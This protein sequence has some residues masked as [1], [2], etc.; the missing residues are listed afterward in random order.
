[1]GAL[2]FLT[3]GESHGPGLVTIVEGMPAGVPIAAAEIDRDLVRRQRGYGRGG[4]QKI[5]RDAIRVLSGIRQGRTIGS[6]IA[7]V[8]ENRDAPNWERVMSVTAIE[9]APAPVTRLRPGH[10]DLAG[11]LKHGYDDV[12]DV[13]ERASARETAARTAAGGV[14][15][16][17]LRELDIAVRS[18]VTQIG[19]VRTDPAW[20]DDRVEASEVRCGDEAASARMVEAIEA[21]RRDGDTL[22]GVVAVRATGVPPGLGSYAQWD[23]RLDGRLAQAVVSIPSVKAMAIG[24]GAQVAAERGSAAHDPIEVR[25]G[26]FSRTRNRAGGLEGGVTNGEHV[27]L[28]VSFKPISTLMKPLPSADLA[29]GEPSPAHIERSDVCVVPAGGVVCEAVVA[30]VLADAILEKFGNDSVDDLRAALERYRSR[31]R[32]LRART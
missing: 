20:D 26:G 11:A 17:L 9:D 19:N 13:I 3:A 21:A 29:T 18:E 27:V 2:R 28:W 30:L 4:R 24:D 32:P 14:A 16:A 8:I 12:R 6:P 1:M 31:L 22:G 7:F 15:K 5:E 10:A 23:R 25:D